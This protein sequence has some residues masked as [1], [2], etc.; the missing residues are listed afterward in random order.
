[1]RIFF[2]PFYFSVIVGCLSCNEGKRSIAQATKVSFFDPMM[3]G[4]AN[5]AGRL[6]IKAQFS[7]CGEW[8]G[9]KEE[10]IIYAD[11]LERFHADYRIFP[12]SCD[13]LTFY[14]ANDNLPPPRI[15]KTIV[16]QENEKKAVIAYIQRLTQSKVNE[17]FIDGA[18]NAGNVFSFVNADA[19]F[20]ISVRNQ[21]QADVDSYRQ[22]IHELFD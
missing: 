16:L 6:S 12:F 2:L 19:T 18:S 22:F 15:S 13:S 21:K 7:E 8:G 5:H 20:S 10:V 9:H 17:R 14:L 11:S 1:M 3:F 4:A